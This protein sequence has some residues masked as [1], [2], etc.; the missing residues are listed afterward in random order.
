MSIEQPWIICDGCGWPEAVCVCAKPTGSCPSSPC[1]VCGD[2]ACYW[3]DEAWFCRHHGPLRDANAAVAKNR[4][5]SPR[6]R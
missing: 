2:P 4:R 1:S 3:N 6:P 5:R